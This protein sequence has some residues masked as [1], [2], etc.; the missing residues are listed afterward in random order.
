M[1]Q[2]FYAHRT[3]SDDKTQW[4]PLKTHLEAVAQRA[5]E[6]A[7]KFGAREWGAAAGLL[8]DF[9][10]FSAKFQKRLEG[11]PIPVDHATAGAQYVIETW[12]NKTA[13]ILAYVIAGHHAGLTDFGSDSGDEACLARRL[14]KAIEPYKESAIAVM[15][16]AAGLTLPP[17]IQWGGNPGLQLSMFI[18]MLFSCLVDADS[19]DSEQYAEKSRTE[20]R[21]HD[22]D[23]SELLEKYETY[24]L[25]RFTTADR[26]INAIRNNLRLECLE[27]AEDDRGMYTLTLPTGSGKTLASLG[28]ALK[29]AVRHGLKRIIYVIPY[30]SIIEQN[31]AIF[32]E[33]L[34]AEYVLEHHSNVQHEMTEDSD[35]GYKLKE[36]LLLA[37]ENWDYPVIVTTNV[38]FFESLFSNRRSRTRKLHNL[39]QSVV[40]VDEAQLMNGDFFKPCLLALEELVRNYGATVVLSTATQPNLAELIRGAVQRPL[41]IRDMVRRVPEIFEQFKR[42]RLDRLGKTDEDRLAERLSGDRQALCVVN[43]RRS[44]RELYERVVARMGADGVF[45]LSARMCPKHRLQILGIIRDRLD[46]G[47]PCV[48]ISTQLV[49]CGVDVDFPVVYRELAG[50]DSIAQAA[51]RC[52]RNGNRAIGTVH[53]FETEAT[54][55]LKG[56]FQLTAGIAR[57]IIERHPDD[58]LSLKAVDEYFQELYFYQKLGGKTDSGDLTDKHNILGQL[59]ERKLS[60][61]DLPFRTIAEQFRLIDTAAKS[62]IVPYDDEAEEY[63]EA[64]LFV[65]KINGIMR[66]L[67]PYVVQL[68]PQEFEAFRQAGEIVEVRADVFKLANKQT[69]YDD[70]VGIK[71]FS[72]EH[73]LAE[74]LIG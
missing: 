35:V 61:C 6:F 52:N 31:A 8:H 48:L 70:Q 64:L 3:D 30:T 42:V 40:V 34:G 72:E 13:R 58:P 10:K 19:L 59:N 12:N 74:V 18:R 56:W 60:D 68:Y 51:G 65:P 73:H 50:L 37:E 9:G 15:G 47:L 63:L 11:S 32:R 1:E 38:Q 22:A 49:E 20:L 69:W 66:K 54:D 57:S 46:N 67:Q 41:P 14:K 4:Q 29:H 36:K 28:F 43:T 39:A 33:V 2:L 45:H 71:P 16:N 21:R 17:P 27:R 44:A 55:K 26:P 53:V 24:V 25:K 62:L 7:S 5:G 23:F